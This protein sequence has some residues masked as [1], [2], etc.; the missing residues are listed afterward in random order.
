MKDTILLVLDLQLTIITLLLA[1]ELWPLEPVEDLL[2]QQSHIGIMLDGSELVVTV[3][4]L[5]GAEPAADQ[6]ARLA[7]DARGLLESIEHRILK[8]E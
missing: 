7:R 3:E 6:A 5:G 8:R 1:G 2:V 4:V